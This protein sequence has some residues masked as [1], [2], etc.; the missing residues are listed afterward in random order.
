M[1]LA[2]DHGEGRRFD[3]ELPDEDRSTPVDGLYVAA[4]VGDSEAQA[5]TS[6]GQ[7]ARVGRTILADVR[8]EQ[9]YPDALADHWDWVRRED[10]LTGEWA[11]RDRWREYADARRP[12]DHAVGDERWV[13]LRERELD[14]R[15]AAYITGDDIERRTERGQRRLLTHLDDDLI[16]DAARE[17]AAERE[18]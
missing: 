10:E 8:R 17:I 16:L 7:G 4:P 3:R 5:I 18:D 2:H 13:E 15:F 1:F 9:G 14:R 12:D 11:D 6:A